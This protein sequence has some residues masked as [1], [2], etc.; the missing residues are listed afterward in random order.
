MADRNGWRERERERERERVWERDFMLS[1]WLDDDDD[2][3]D[4]DFFKKSF[5]IGT[6]GPW[7][8]KLEKF[9]LDFFY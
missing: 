4:D 3:D 6:W 1:A 9:L 5:L 7:Y 8:N 2:D